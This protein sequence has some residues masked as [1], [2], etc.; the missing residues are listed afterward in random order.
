MSL[1]MYLNGHQYFYGLTAE[2]RKTQPVGHIYQ[3]GHWHN[4][5]GLHGFIA[6]SFGYGDG[7]NEEINLDSDDLENIIEAIQNDE[8]PNMEG[9]L[10]GKDLSHEVDKADVIASFQDA[11]IWL[12]APDESGSRYV[13]YMAVW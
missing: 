5:P 6:A 4:H 13:T 12:L 3:F 1:T 2:K 8:L 7:H 9:R 11:I 10:P